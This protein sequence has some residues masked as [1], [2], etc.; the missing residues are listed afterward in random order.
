MKRSFPTDAIGADG[1]RYR[2]IL[3]LFGVASKP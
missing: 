2:F 1:G 3:R